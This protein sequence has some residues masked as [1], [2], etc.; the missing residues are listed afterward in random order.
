VGEGSGKKTNSAER[1]KWRTKK[2]ND[3]EEQSS[4]LN[5]KGGETRDISWPRITPG[6][7]GKARSLVQRDGLKKEHRRILS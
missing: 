7:Q 6:S 5:P 4:D 1:S 2:G 3:Y